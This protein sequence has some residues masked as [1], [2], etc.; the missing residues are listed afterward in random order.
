MYLTQTIEEDRS[1][2]THGRDLGMLCGLALPTF[3]YVQPAIASNAS[4]ETFAA[5]ILLL[6]DQLTKQG[7]SLITYESQKPNIIGSACSCYVC[8]MLISMKIEACL[9]WMYVE[10]PLTSSPRPFLNNVPHSATPPVC[11]ISSI[12]S[13]LLLACSNNSNMWVKK[14]RKL[15]YSTGHLLIYPWF[16]FLFF[17]FF[18]ILYYNMHMQWIW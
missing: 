15:R 14:K 16:Y 1:M 12:Y 7:I 18:F 5:Y 4:Y 9:T 13:P 8:F 10:D 11:T 6:I 3:L 2:R 17:I